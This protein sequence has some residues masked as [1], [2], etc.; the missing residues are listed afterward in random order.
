M[1]ELLGELGQAPDMTQQL[2]TLV[3]EL[4]QTTQTPSG[5][6]SDTPA[7]AATPAPTTS[8]AAGEDGFQ[9]QIRRTME[10]MQASGEQASAAAASSSS[11]SPDDILAQMLAEMEKGG[12]GGEGGGGAGGESDEDFSKMLMGMM[13]QLTNKEILYE[14]MKELHDKLPGWLAKNREATGK[15]D[16]ERYEEQQRCV[17]AIV[18]RFERPGYSDESAADREFI[19]DKMQKVCTMADSR[20]CRGE[21]ITD[22]GADAG[23]GVTAAG[24]G[25]RYELGARGFGRAGSGVRDS[26][27]I[28]R[29]RS[30]LSGV[31]MTV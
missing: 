19:V 20:R 1:A 13:E 10:R 24:F 17:S 29:S 7:A 2:E 4:G 27:M 18:E 28:M 25:W 9:D 5:G 30:M 11:S 23:S 26:I 8:G 31:S 22:T 6:G 21:A 15:E 3:K 12:F 14:P 16:L